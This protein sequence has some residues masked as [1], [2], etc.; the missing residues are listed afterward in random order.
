M[1][2]T[3][4]LCTMSIKEKGAEEMEP[5]MEIRVDRKRKSKLE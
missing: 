3:T 1:D 2:N 4:H 5:E